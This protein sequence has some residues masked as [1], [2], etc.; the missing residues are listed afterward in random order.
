MQRRATFGSHHVCRRTCSHEQPSAVGT[1]FLARDVEW[2]RAVGSGAIEHY[3]VRGQEK[4]H[5]LWEANDT[6]PGRPRDAAYNAV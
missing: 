3:V 6:A 5:Q 2:R 1:V 4:L